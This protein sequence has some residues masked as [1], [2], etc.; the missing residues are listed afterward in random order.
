ME[1]PSQSEMAPITVVKH[2]FSDGDFKTAYAL[3]LPFDIWMNI[4]L[5]ISIIDLASLRLVHNNIYLF[6]FFH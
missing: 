4:S 5:F 2:K 6:T 1:P 3:V